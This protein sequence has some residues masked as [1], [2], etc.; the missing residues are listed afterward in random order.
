MIDKNTFYGANR[1]QT[2]PATSSF[3]E[4]AKYSTATPT[5]L[6]IGIA[7]IWTINVGAGNDVVLPPAN[8]SF[9]NC[10]RLGGPSF[11][12]VNVGSV[13]FS[14]KDDGGNVLETIAT[15]KAVL[16][17]LAANVTANGNWLRHI[18]DVG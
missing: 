2:I 9:Q 14:L 1:A 3:L 17:C 11:L 5:N 13:S 18:Y 15:D 8:G 7:R 6:N 10:G 4:G 16:V 12:I